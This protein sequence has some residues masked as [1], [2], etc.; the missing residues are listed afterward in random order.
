MKVLLL[1]P[2]D[3]LPSGNSRWDLVIDTARAPRS[4]YQARGQRT[5]GRVVSIYDFAE[6]VEDLYRIRKLLDLGMGRLLDVHG[7]DWWDVCSLM[8]SPDLQQLMLARRLAG[9]LDGACEVHATRDSSFARGIQAVLGASVVVQRRVSTL[10]R[11][12]SS[13]LAARKLDAGELL[14]VLQ[15]KFDVNHGFRRY[16][17]ARPVSSGNPVVLSPSAY[18]NVTRTIARRA[19]GFPEKEFYLVLARRS[20]GIADLP[21]NVRV[22][23][24]DGYF[25]RASMDEFRA[26]LQEWEALRERLVLSSD[27]FL[28]ADAAGVLLRIPSLLRWGLAVRDAWLRVLETENVVEC[29]CADDSNPYTRIPLILAKKRRLPTLACHHGALDNRMAFKRSHAD[30]YL[31]KSEMERDYTVRICRVPADRVVFERSVENSI[32]QVPARGGSGQGCI[33]F[34]TEAYH[35]AGFREEEIYR[36][37]MP[38]MLTAGHVLGL[39]VV[40]KLHP[41]DSVKKLQQSL[42]SV[43]SG[44]DRRRVHIWSGAMSEERWWKTRVAVTGQSSVSLDSQSRGIPTFLCQWLSDPFS[45]YQKQFVSFGIGR[46]LSS[47]AEVGRIPEMLNEAADSASS[48]TPFALTNESGNQFPAPVAAQA[49]TGA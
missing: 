34:F 19:A 17:S 47:V 16:L 49:T 42:R 7:V 43:L 27:E 31:V 20:A 22:A 25:G 45:G 46:L 48:R 39:R 37:L 4:T 40:I 9:E 2:A 1:H 26:L 36:E 11:F 13:L 38:A 6:E 30:A 3:D 29:F 21:E 24:L 23:S 8:I 41:F 5:G 10:D 15:D 35:S 28:M 32:A 18:I 14:Q 44:V 12:R 33:V